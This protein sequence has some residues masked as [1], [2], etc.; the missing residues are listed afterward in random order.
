VRIK[1]AFI[2]SLLWSFS[3]EAQNLL[4]QKLD[5][6]ARQLNRNEALLKLS[7]QTGIDISYS[8]SFFEEKNTLSLELAEVTLEEVLI[9]ILKATAVEFKL[10]GKRVVLFLP[11][12]ITIGGYVEDQSSGERLISATVFDKTQNIGVI[13]NEYGFFSLTVE[14]GKTILEISYVGYSK[15][16]FLIGSDIQKKMNIILKPNSELE[17]VLV[18]A[19]SDEL[20]DEDQNKALEISR[21]F[22]RNSPALGGE[23]D[24][25][26]TAQLLP[27]IDAGV[28]GFGG[29]QVRGGES[30]QNLMMLDGVT[31]YIPYHLLGAFSIYNPN[32]VRSAKVLKSNFPARYGGRLSSI[33]DIRTREGNLYDW[34]AK[35]SASLV[36]LSA[37]VE[38]PLKKG[39]GSILLAG[40]FSPSGALFNSFFKRAYF[41]D[42]EID[43][44]SGFYDLNLKL[45]YVLTPKDRVYL[46]VFH[47]RDALFHE[48]L[49]EDEEEEEI[50]NAELEF[51][52][53]NTIGSLRWNHL[54]NEKL[55]SNL[56]L[57]YSSYGYNLTSFTQI[58]ALEA[59]EE[60]ELYYFANATENRDVGVKLDFDYA[61]DNNHHFR[62]G[63]GFSIR[64]FS[65]EISYFE[66]ED[67]AVIDLDT[68]TSDLLD[69][70]IEA[71]TFQ[72][73]EG[74]L[75]IEDQIR[76]S[77][78]WSANL[79]VRLSSFFNEDSTFI[80]TEPR[81]LLNYQQNKN[82]SWHVSATRMVQYLHLVTNA[83]LRL[84]ND[85]WLPSS[86]ELLPQSSWQYEF[87]NRFE[88]N[89]SWS[90]SSSL[91][92]KNMKN[93]YAYPDNT[94]Y[95]E[96]INEDPLD[97]FLI[98]GN[99]LAY[100]LETLLKYSNG[101]FVGILSY[102]LA[103]SERQFD[104]HNLG[105]PYPFDFDQRHRFKLFVFK[106]YKHFQFGLNWVYLSASPRVS[107]LPLE[108]GE[109]NVKIELNPPGEKNEL[110]SE[111]YH[112]MDLSM[113][114]QFKTSSTHHQFKLGL[115]NVY[116]NQNVAHFESN[117]ND[118]DII[119]STNP[120]HALG[121]LPSISYS[122]KF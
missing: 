29:L 104:A 87:G 45:N 66:A 64:Q 82:L 8:P 112:R 110:R 40:R 51:D 13:T 68:I 98:R 107:I 52:W 103:K 92:L 109:G 81:F 7:E 94:A 119:T 26:R 77:H 84:P 118:D 24:F 60:N 55:F 90:I 49:S 117:I 106:Q 114:Y 69:D 42:T 115:N 19:N 96:D 73:Y 3:L 33:L 89:S 101:G 65:P 11:K 67:D 59:E 39:K 71:D 56:T 48:R 28:D 43:L 61:A 46:S 37:T 79:G 121:V 58:E 9:Q 116:N 38:G 25:V 41:Q 35:A 100:G 4:Q 18:Q 44:S 31:I 72:A 105:D 12:Q 34:E 97:S 15:K 111:P 20:F 22:V 95:L 10:V 86:D 50:V 93:I 2:L 75:Y 78:K 63:G 57:T 85:L 16:E 6:E 88:I 122:I 62:F 23:E 27:G 32:T 83:A 113:G 76:F 102:T 91:Y 74:F 99:G 1:I 36:N 120:I 108:D 21:K 53:N 17:E 47:G 54:F 70:L 14:P 80:R 5:F 30:G